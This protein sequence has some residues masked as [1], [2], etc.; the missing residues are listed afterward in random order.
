MVRK[1]KPLGTVISVNSHG[2]RNGDGDTNTD[3]DSDK[4]NIKHFRVVDT[5]Y[6]PIS[7]YIQQLALGKPFKNKDR[8]D[9]RDFKDTPIRKAF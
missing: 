6:F 8:K 3:T 1:S 2:N 5:T 4:G 9:L 7:S